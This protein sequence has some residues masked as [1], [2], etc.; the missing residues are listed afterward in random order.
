MP[1]TDI[2]QINKIKAELEQTRKERDALKNLVAE[3]ERLSLYEIKQAIAQ[4]EEQRSQVCREFETQRNKANRETQELQESLA[5]KRQSLDQQ[6]A[7]L[8]RQIADKKKD[9]IILDDELLLQSLSVN[10]VETPA[11][12][13]AVF[14]TTLAL[15]RGSQVGLRA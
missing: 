15:P 10:R 12:R 4:L 5:R 6:I 13:Q 7:D 1:I 2:F 14:N 11:F 3:T 9:L 8:N